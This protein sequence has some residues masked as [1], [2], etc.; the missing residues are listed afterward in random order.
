MNSLENLILQKVQIGQNFYFEIH[1]QIAISL[2][3]FD[4]F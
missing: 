2:S 3:I 1:A 4:G